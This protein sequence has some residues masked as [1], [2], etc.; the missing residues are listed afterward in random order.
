MPIGEDG[1]D[2]GLPVWLQSL[3]G[4][5]NK[6][7]DSPPRPTGGVPDE[8]SLGDISSGGSDLR[9]FGIGSSEPANAMGGDEEEARPSFGARI[10]GNVPRP[11]PAAPPAEVAPQPKFDI[12]FSKLPP[13]IAPTALTPKQVPQPPTGTN[14]P[15]LSDLARQ[16]GE[17]GKPLDPS[18]VDPQTGKPMY[19]MGTGQRILGTAANFLQ[20]FGGKP[21]TPTYVGPGATNGRFARDESMRQGKLANVNTQIGTQEKLDTENEKMYRDAIRQAYEG[22]VGEARKDTAAAQGENAETKRML[23]ASQAERN[24]A[25]ADKAN[26]VPSDQRTKDANAQGLTGQARKD[27]ILTGKLPKDFASA[28]RQPT[29]LEMW[30]DAFV[31][32]NK[33]QPTADEIANRKS[34]TDT[35][36]DEITKDR[37]KALKDAERKASDS[38]AKIK[39]PNPKDADFLS[40]LKNPQAWTEGK[41]QEIYS[42]LEKEK[43]LAVN[44]YQERAAQN[45]KS[46]ATTTAP[47]AAASA[48]KPQ[49]KVGE[50]IMVAGKPRKVVGW[51]PTSKKPIVAPEGQ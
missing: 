50:T 39:P 42:Q 35:K 38:I 10:A 41:K 49:P 17:L 28:G 13:G 44:D 19:K 31:R 7:T 8:N 22:Q 36:S 26:A 21:F 32:D 30:R 11:A 43:A 34:R 6:T 16:Q 40:Y 4:G 33:R 37:D 29:E 15:N 14:N 27:Y 51:N 18:A 2:Q 12:D 1:N 48:P 45:S 23:E 9:R 46:K 24:Q 3:L 20:G 5:S 25:M 47:P